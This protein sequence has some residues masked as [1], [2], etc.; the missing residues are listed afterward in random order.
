M[1]H[2]KQLFTFLDKI[3]T[4]AAESN[5]Q[6]P[7]VKQAI[8]RSAVWPSVVREVAVVFRYVF[9]LASCTAFFNKLKKKKKKELKETMRMSYR[10]PVKKQ[11]R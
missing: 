9:G 6:N 1:N 8:I 10:T 11:Y 2:I 4:M 5:W 3:G 7:Q